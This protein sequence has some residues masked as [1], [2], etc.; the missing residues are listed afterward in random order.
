[1][2][3][4]CKAQMYSLVVKRAFGTTQ[5]EDFDV[6]FYGESSSGCGNWQKVHPVMADQ[7]LY[8]YA[9]TQQYCSNIKCKS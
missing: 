5:Q 2:N 4:L 8:G 7:T 1:M 6:E 3:Q 9:I